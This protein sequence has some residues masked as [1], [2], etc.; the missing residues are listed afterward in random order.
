MYETWQVSGGEALKERG[1]K[2]TGGRIHESVCG[3]DKDRIVGPKRV[4]K[5]DVRERQVRRAYFRT[6][7]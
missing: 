6:R 1:E 2:V 3:C 4:S 5:K 7:T